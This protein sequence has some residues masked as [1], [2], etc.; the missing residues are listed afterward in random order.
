M[1]LKQLIVTALLVLLASKVS[2]ADSI[3]ISQVDTDDL[4]LRQQVK[5]YLSITDDRGNPIPNL[6]REHLTVSESIYGKEFKKVNEIYQLQTGVNY[7]NGISFLLLIDNSESMYWTL[8]GKKTDVEARRR[9][10]IARSAVDSFLKSI[11]NPNDRVGIA[12]YN[13]YYQLLSAPSNAIGTV[14]DQLE[15]ISRPTGDAIYT[16]IYA[17]LPLAIRELETVRG[18]KAVIIL[19]DGVNNPAYP[20]TNKINQQFGK[21]FV[22]YTKPLEMLQLEGISLYVI[23]FGSKTDKKDRHLKTIAKQSGGVTFDAHNQAQLNQVYSRIMKQIQNELVLTY[24]ATMDLADKKQVKVTYKKGDESDS[25]TRVYVSSTVFGQASPSFHMLMLLL[26]LVAI[27]LLWLLSKIKFERQRKSPSLEVLNAGAGK[28]STQVL[29]LGGDETVIGSS[30]N[31]DI[32]IAGLPTIEENHATV[33]FDQSS[34]RYSLKG[35]GKLLVNNQP[36]TT[37]ILEPGDLINIDG[38]TMVFDEGK[39]EDSNQ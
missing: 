19:S 29:T 14:G 23:Y 28:L 22:P 25:V 3:R 18:R 16:E 9:M 5:L 12:T 7:T 15:K 35:K 8:E 39:K 10:T 6:N 31:A 4:L 26:T 30:P 11:T 27:A 34:Q 20:H 38:T 17:S 37:K 32:T 1:R 13:S 24:R 2:I 33:V 36:V 21:R